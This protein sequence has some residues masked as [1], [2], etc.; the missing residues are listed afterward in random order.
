MVKLVEAIKQEIEGGRNYF[1]FEFFAP[2]TEY[3]LETLY[4][5]I[6]R[7]A[8]LDPL[9][10]SIT[11]GE[12][13]STAD[14]SMDVA[15]TSQ[16][17]LS[18][19]FQVNVT[20]FTSTEEEMAQWLSKLKAKGVRNLLVTRGRVVP[21]IANPAFPHAVDLIRFI[22]REFGDFFGI[23]AVAAPE[24]VGH[25]LELEVERTRLKVQS[26]ADYIITEAVFDPATFQHFFEQCR[27]G[28]ISCPIL[29]S[30]MALS[31]P[32]QMDSFLLA[33]RA[34]A[35]EFREKLAAA[36]GETESRR[37]AVAFFQ[38]LVQALLASGVGGAYFFTLNTETL[39]API[40]KGMKLISLRPFPWKPSENEERRRQETVRPIHWSSRITSYM[41][42]TAQWDSFKEGH[43]RWQGIES[44]GY[45]AKLLLRSR[46]KRCAQFA[47]L[48]DVDDI[49]AALSELSEIFINFLGGNGTLPWAEEL[50]GETDLVTD[51]VLKP[52][53]ARGLYTIN[54][55]PR[56]NGAPS[57]DP[58][59]GWGPAGGV[60]YQKGYLEFFCPPSHA[61]TVLQ[62]LNRY[63]S[64]QYLCMDRAGRLVASRWRTEER[65]DTANRLS[66]QQSIFNLFGEGV[67]VVTWGV[68]PGREVV[69]PT[70]VSVASTEAWVSEAFDLWSAPF[71]SQ[72]PPPVVRMIQSEWLLVNIVDNDYVS[73]AS[74]LEAAVEEVCTKIPTLMGTGAFSRRA[75]ST[76]DSLA[77]P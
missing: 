60:V 12:Y 71:P 67:V 41:V 43:K 33:D 29:P 53:N 24:P 21:E 28:G 16:S 50:S 58:V 10:S 5:K 65:R 30:V 37:V 59:V 47:A 64:L 68:F 38:G 7:M 74:A 17:L 72:E 46:A 15:A 3:G 51:T 66:S 69:Q 55:Q 77:A 26:G 76:I 25:S 18:I 9:F 1:G 39:L 34:G 31:S 57:A 73:P 42:R 35:R 32:R 49:A 8:G 63:P 44:S 45:H 13:G 20:G 48:A 22:R 70:I 40:L 56:V 19:H 4:D 2:T 11:W 14:T 23:A 75:T 36:Q 6:E 61:P 54:S 62:T 52:L 27:K